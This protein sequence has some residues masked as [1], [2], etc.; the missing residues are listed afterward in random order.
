MGDVH[1]IVKIERDVLALL[2][3]RGPDPVL[4]C[5]FSTEETQIYLRPNRPDILHMKIKAYRI[6]SFH[7]Q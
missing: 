7:S 5:V 4:H 2:F 6:H 3:S 1:F